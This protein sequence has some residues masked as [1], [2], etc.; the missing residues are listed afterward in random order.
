[1]STV[2]SWPLQAI[3]YVLQQF[4]IEPDI[5]IV[6]R[7]QYTPPWR[8]CQVRDNV[9]TA[10]KQVGDMKRLIKVSVR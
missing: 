8:Q 10:L 2:G 5:L 6:R 9:R 7:K 3:S 1:M 4:T